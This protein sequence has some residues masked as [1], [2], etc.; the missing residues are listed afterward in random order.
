[1][2]VIPANPNVYYDVHVLTSITAGLSV[3]VR[4]DTSYPI[5]LQT[6]LT[7]PTSDSGAVIVGSG[8]SYS[9][10]PRTSN[11]WIRAN[12]PVSIEPE[13]NNPSLPV[14]RVELPT[15][16]YTSTKE[17]FRRVRIDIGQTGFFEGREFRT[18]KEFSI[19]TGQTYV[20]KVVV[21][22][23]AILFSQGVELDA[24]SIRITNATGGTP[25]GTFSETLPVIG[26]N[27]MSTRPTPFY[28]PQI[29]FTAGGTHTGGFIFDVHRVVTSQASSQEFTVGAVTADE[30]GIAAATYYVRYENIGIG[31]ATGTFFFFWEER[32]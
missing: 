27:N 17:G 21:P 18:F 3:V 10:S 7:L 31:T 26:K 22:I 14:S 29:V 24:G 23:N 32:P 8:D 9:F 16:I 30:R 28:V 2:I 6:S 15:D 4:N 19:P 11:L 25:G 1:M 13:A 12:G 20:V 5:F